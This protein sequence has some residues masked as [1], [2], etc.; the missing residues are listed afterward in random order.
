MF[1]RQMHVRTT[2]RMTVGKKL[3]TDEASKKRKTTSLNYSESGKTSEDKKD[4]VDESKKR[5][6]SKGKVETVNNEQWTSPR[7]KQTKGG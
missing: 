3:V 5:R 4:D 2:C 7:K 6:K 1:K